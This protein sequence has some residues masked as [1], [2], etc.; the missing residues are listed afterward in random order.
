MPIGELRQ[1]TS[2]GGYEQL[3]CGAMAILG[4][5]AEEPRGRSDCANVVEKGIGGDVLPAAG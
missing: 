5:R 1:Q 3:L 2:I 4:G